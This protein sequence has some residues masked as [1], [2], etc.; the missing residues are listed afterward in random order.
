MP[1][2]SISLAPAAVSTLVAGTFESSAATTLALT[3]SSDGAGTFISLPAVV[4]AAVFGRSSLPVSAAEALD[5]SAAGMRVVAFG[6]AAVEGAV[7]VAAA[8]VRAAASAR[9]LPA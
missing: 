7:D 3:P 8:L 1:L 2:V 6:G 9:L 5:A 4:V